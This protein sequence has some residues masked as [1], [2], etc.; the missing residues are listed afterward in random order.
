MSLNNISILCLLILFCTVPLIAQNTVT[1]NGA[2]SYIPIWNSDTNLGNSTLFQNGVNVGI[3]TTSPLS[4]LEADVNASRTLGPTLTLTNTG[5][6]PGAA[7][8]VD[9]NSYTPVPV[10]YNPAARI[11]ALDD[12]WSDDIV[13]LSNKQGAANSGLQA[14]LTVFANGH[15]GVGYPANNDPGVRLGVNGSITATTS[16]SKSV[17]LTA[18]SDAD[19]G[20]GIVGNSLGLTGGTG[21]FAYSTGTGKGAAGVY[22]ETTGANSNALYSWCASNC[23]PSG[24]AGYF[25]GNVTVV[26]SF[27]VQGGT[28]N[29]KIDDPSDPAGKYLYHASIES[30]EMI[31]LYTGNATLD[32]SGAAT[33]QLPAW[34]QAENSDYRYSLTC[35]GGFAPVYISE[36][37]SRN[38]FKIAGGKPEMKVSWQVTG[39]RQDAYAK[40]HPLEAEVEKPSQEQGYYIYPELYGAPEEKNVER[41]RRPEMQKTMEGRK[42]K[43]TPL[44]TSA[45]Q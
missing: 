16:D 10:K 36:E 38:Q 40:A 29:F 4:I 31:N 15:V 42:E 21:V 19:N 14:N 39:T 35:V 22:A 3:G 6:N 12:N 18:T 45:P 9:F 41:A 23:S 20:E 11:E 2:P 7:A 43:A 44:A 33:V 30:S 34:F 37:V 17:A 28:K 27:T 8:S 5:G 26:G 13:F 32:A 25:V 24:Y 1:G